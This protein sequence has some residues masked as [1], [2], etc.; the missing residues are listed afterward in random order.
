MF[1]YAYDGFLDTEQ[2]H[3]S[4]IH[5][6]AVNSFLFLNASLLYKHH[7]PSLQN[8]LLTLCKYIEVSCCMGRIS[9]IL[10]VYLVLIY[11][12]LW[13]RLSPMDWMFYDS[14]ASVNIC[15]ACKKKNHIASLQATF[16]LF[17]FHFILETYSTIFFFYTYVLIKPAL[18]SF[19]WNLHR[20]CNFTL[21][22]HTPPSLW[23]VN[24][25]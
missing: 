23:S 15:A 10:F 21:I 9:R 13:S 6:Q 17:F 11:C 12:Y 25:S 20:K 18:F 3:Y 8:S 7:L 2:L 14:S 1:E 24:L 16:A 19:P 22:P 5:P 4:V